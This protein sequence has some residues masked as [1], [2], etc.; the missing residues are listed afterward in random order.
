MTQQKLQM[1]ALDQLSLDERLQARVGG[2]NERVA[3]EYADAMQNGDVFPP[4]AVFDDG[5]HLWLAGGYHRVH[6]RRLLGVTEIEAVVRKGTFKEAL[7][8]ALLDNARHGLP[9][10]EEDKRHAVEVLL[11]D[12]EW[13]EWSTNSMAQKLN[14]SWGFVDRIRAQLNA[15]S[16]PI[17]KFKKNDEVMTMVVGRRGLAASAVY[18]LELPTARPVPFGE[19]KSSD[20]PAAPEAAPARQIHRDASGHRIPQSLVKAFSDPLHQDAPAQIER[21][22]ADFTAASRW[23]KWLRLRELLDALAEARI[24]II[25]A[26]PRLVHREC[27]GRGCADCR[28]SG[29]LSRW[30]VDQQ[31]LDQP[32]SETTAQLDEVPS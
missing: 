2:V 17:V 12:P 26:Q 31:E 21:L 5:A 27:K 1:L 15:K 9:R 20:D 30:A 16:A 11:A 7:L 19:S 25:E 23:S 8:F 24:C 28:R 10:T 3:R 6:A 13:R 18:K 29:Y 22:M 32:A 4:A 14:L